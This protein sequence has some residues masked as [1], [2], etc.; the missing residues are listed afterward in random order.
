M[1]IVKQLSTS[2][3]INWLA[4]PIF[5]PFL[6]NLHNNLNLSCRLSIRKLSN[7]NGTAQTSFKEKSNPILQTKFG[8]LVSQN[9]AMLPIL[10]AADTTWI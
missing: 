2:A 7:K 1:H 9:Q 4:V 5:M 10:P 3:R 8:W 6:D